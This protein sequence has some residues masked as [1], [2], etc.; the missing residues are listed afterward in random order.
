M[1]VYVFKVGSHVSPVDFELLILLTSLLNVLLQLWDLRIAIP[2]VFC[3]ILRTGIACFWGV[4]L[5]DISVH[6]NDRETE[7]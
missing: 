4:G 6:Q 7:R 1:C 2:C 3:M 5:W